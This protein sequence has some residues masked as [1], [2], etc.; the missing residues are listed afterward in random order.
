[1]SKVCEEG[2][3]RGQIEDSEQ[4][5]FQLGHVGYTSWSK[6]M[7]GKVQ[8]AKM[9]ERGEKTWRK[10]HAI[11]LHHDPREDIIHTLQDRQPRVDA[12]DVPLVLV[13]FGDLFPVGFRNLSH[14]LRSSTADLPRLLCSSDLC[15]CRTNTPVALYT[16]SIAWK[17]WG[18]GQ[19]Y[20][21]LRLYLPLHPT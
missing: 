14:Q 13:F 1:M 7:P 17:A 11:I 18:K 5:Q 8:D 2:L 6:R 10:T 21:P 12:S 4:G 16:R 3:A 9:Q 15:R 19:T 20:I